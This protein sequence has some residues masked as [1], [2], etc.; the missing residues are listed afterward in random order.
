M[1]QGRQAHVWRSF[2]LS[3]FEKGRVVSLS[4]LGEGQGEGEDIG[5][6]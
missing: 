6:I 2:F 4:L 5:R 3:V 1:P